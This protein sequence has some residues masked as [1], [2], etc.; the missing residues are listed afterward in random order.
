MGTLG[1]RMDENCVHGFIRN[2]GIP[3]VQYPSHIYIYIYMYVINSYLR[4][5]NELDPYGHRQALFERL[6]CW[7][8]LRVV[9]PTER[10]AVMIPDRWIDCSNLYPTSEVVLLGIVIVIGCGCCWWWL[11]LLMVD[12]SCSCSCCCLFNVSLVFTAAKTSPDPKAQVARLGAKLFGAKAPGIRRLVAPKFFH[13]LKEPDI[14]GACRKK[15]PNNPCMVYLYT[16][17]S[18]LLGTYTIHGLKHI[19]YESV[20]TYIM[21]CNESLQSSKGVDVQ[22]STL[23][24]AIILFQRVTGHSQE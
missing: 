3:V 20:W 14:S 5:T 24:W 23:T 8:V 4:Q 1:K 15:C 9:L 16:F 17:G 2:Y 18:L 7:T 11:L 22:L 13:Q 6:G 10:K 12:C 19:L 21:K